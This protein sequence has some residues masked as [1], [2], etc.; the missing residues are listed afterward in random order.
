MRA[1]SPDLKL[2]GTP[3]TFRPVAAHALA[4]N[5]VTESPSHVAHHNV[6]ILTT[7]DATIMEG[8]L[9]RSEIRALVWKRLGATH[10]L[11][12]TERI[13]V[14]IRRLKAI[15]HSPRFTD[16]VPS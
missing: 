4:P 2:A 15:G 9:S 14:L 8:L 1:R 5:A 16:S 10:A 6:A 3:S 7:E 12:D 13:Q 11:V